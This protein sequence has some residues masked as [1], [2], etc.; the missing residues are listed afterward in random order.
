M[1][2][3]TSVNNVVEFTDV[4][5]RPW[6]KQHLGFDSIYLQEQDNG[7]IKEI[8]RR[9]L[10]KPLPADLGKGKARMSL[11]N[12]DLSDISQTSARVIA[13]LSDKEEL[14]TRSTRIEKYEY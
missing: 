2:A 4:E 8:Q 6:S 11:Y 1:L 10:L 3:V 7:L 12:T 13:G 9:Q 5:Y 14:D